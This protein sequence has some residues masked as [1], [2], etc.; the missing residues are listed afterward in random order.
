MLPK[1]SFLDRTI[2]VDTK[3]KSITLTQECCLIYDKTFMLADIKK[4]LYQHN[5]MFHELDYHTESNIVKLY[6]YMTGES[7]CHD[8]DDFIPKVG[9]HI[10]ETRMRK[11][12]YTFLSNLCKEN[13]WEFNKKLDNVLNSWNKYGYCFYRE[14]KHLGELIDETK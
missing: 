14:D 9:L 4:V 2:D 13:Y 11:K 5:I 1:I 7:T 3:S 10:A 8:S 6:F 12:V